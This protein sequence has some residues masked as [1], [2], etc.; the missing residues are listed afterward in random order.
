MKKAYKSLMRDTYKR[1]EAVPWWKGYVSEDWITEEVR[2][3]PIPFNIL[4]QV[5]FFLW[6]TMQRGM[7]GHMN[8]VNRQRKIRSKAN[9]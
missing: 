2:V 1:Y 7:C 5:A 6:I 8:F 4:F 3:A 9:N